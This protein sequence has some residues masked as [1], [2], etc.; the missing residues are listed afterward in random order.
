MYKTM[1]EYIWKGWTNDVKICQ[2]KNKHNELEF[3]KIKYT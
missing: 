2:I 3:K 1:Y